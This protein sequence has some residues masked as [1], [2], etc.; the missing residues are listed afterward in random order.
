MELRSLPRTP[1]YV[2]FLAFLFAFP[3][4]WLVF[5]I[6]GDAVPG[7]IRMVLHIALFGMIAIGLETLRRRF[8]A[9]RER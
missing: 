1:Y 3:L 7:M 6:I 2:Y 5:A 8:L 9:K 4:G